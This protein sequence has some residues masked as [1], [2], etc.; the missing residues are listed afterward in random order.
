MKFL[1]AALFA[2]LIFGA[3][4]AKELKHCHPCADDVVA[5]MV[6]DLQ[7]EGWWQMV[8]NG[9]DPND[10]TYRAFIKDALLSLAM[11]LPEGDFRP[12]VNQILRDEP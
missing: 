11:R 9:L 5:A 8:P 1:A 10:E 2:T 7:K 12:I 3:A 6:V 4:D